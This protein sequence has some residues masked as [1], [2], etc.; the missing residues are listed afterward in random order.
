MAR[1]F[2]QCFCKWGKRWEFEIGHSVYIQMKFR[3]WQC[4]AW[5]RWLVTGFDPGIV[6]VRF[7]LTK[8]HRH[9]IFSEYF[10]FPMSVPF[11]YCSI[12]IHAPSCCLCHYNLQF[13]TLKQFF[14][15]FLSTAPTISEKSYVSE[16]LGFARWSF[17]WTWVWSIGE[18]ILTGETRSTGWKTCHSATFPTTNLT[19]NDQGS[20]REL[21]QWYTSELNACAVVELEARVWL[22]YYLNGSFTPD[23][24]P[25]FTVC[26]DHTL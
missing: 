14:I 6:R 26:T 11:H 1:Y 12:P 5:L 13:N 16:F 21:S 9:R 18:M 20:N 10:R 4:H 2:L 3:L 24:E 23:K 17:W 22:T 25:I 15:S 7:V 8:R 19:W